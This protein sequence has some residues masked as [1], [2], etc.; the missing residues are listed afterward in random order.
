MFF[1]WH[2]SSLTAALL[3]AASRA[4]AM[5]LECAIDKRTDAHQCFAPSELRE[6]DG[7]RFAPLYAGGPKGLTRTSY[8]VHA[9][10]RTEVL[11]LKDRQG[12]SFGGGSFADTDMSRQ[13]GRA[14]CDASVPAP[15]RGK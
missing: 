9:N 1:V 10:C 14:I 2:K 12:V 3:V 13:M 6:V 7:I 11:H 4:G 5:P 8:S 15:K